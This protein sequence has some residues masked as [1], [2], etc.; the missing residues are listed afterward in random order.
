MS[1]IIRIV[2]N[3]IGLLVI[4]HFMDSI[5]VESFTTAIIAV[6][7]LSVV[8]TFI[9]PI[10][11]LLSLP[12][13]FLTLG[14]FALVVNGALFYLVASFVDGFQVSSFFGAIVGSIFMSIVYSF[15]ANKN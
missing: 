6:V 2:L 1:L 5:A 12:I 7:V 8:N 15:T 11:Q 10:L 14:L 3:A 13:T 9:R 4:D